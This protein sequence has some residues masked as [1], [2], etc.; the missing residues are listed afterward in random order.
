MMRERMS[1]AHT[2]GQENNTGITVV[3][4]GDCPFCTRY[5]QLLRL[6]ENTG[7]VRMINA[8][9]PDETADRLREEGIELDKGIVVLWRGQIYQADRALHL[10]ASLSGDKGF[11]NRLTRL[12]F[13]SPTLTRWLYPFLYHGRNLALKLTGKT[14]ITR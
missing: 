14:R 10:L 3:Y 2:D 13:K 8:R 1:M 6:R 11:F 7:H 5:S 9:E 12:A 4:D